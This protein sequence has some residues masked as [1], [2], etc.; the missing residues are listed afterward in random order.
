MS[1]AMLDDHSFAA[2]MVVW[3]KQRPSNVNSG[4]GEKPDLKQAAKSQS[5][6]DLQT[7]EIQR[8][9]HVLKSMGTDILLL[10]G[11]IPYGRE[12][13]EACRV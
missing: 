9:S 6:Y 8:R 5:G 13:Y 11:T 4:L 12:L 3:Y 7:W 10:K 2:Q 1:I